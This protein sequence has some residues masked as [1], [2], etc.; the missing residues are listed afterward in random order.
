MR[1]G[2]AEVL[3][4]AAGARFEPAAPVLALLAI[5][6]PLTAG[7]GV[8]RQ[9][10]LATDRQQYDLVVVVLGAVSNAGLN[11]LL[12]PRL[13]LAG[14]ALATITGEAVVLVAAIVVA[15]VTRGP[16]SVVQE[17]LS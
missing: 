2:A 16:S 3:R 8:L 17:S 14:A 4:L 15:V 1:V 12:I 10:L 6:I 11:L 9:V 7:A 5:S 13:G